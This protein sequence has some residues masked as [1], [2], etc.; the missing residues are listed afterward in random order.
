V[1][2]A[3]MT[4]RIA[5]VSPRFKARIA[6][7]FYLLTILMGAFAMVFAGRKL[8]V[9]GDAANLIATACYTAVTPLFYDMFKPVNRG[10]S[11]LAAR[12][13][14]SW[15]APLG[16]LAPFISPPPTSTV[17]YFSDSIAS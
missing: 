5:E 16:L 8:F 14:A 11:L 13:S 10:L 7:V 4:E 9:Y 15:D 6:G 3:G 17:W 1:T 12:S 2:T